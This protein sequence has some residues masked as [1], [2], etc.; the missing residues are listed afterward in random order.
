MRAPRRVMG[1]WDG[2]LHSCPASGKILP[3]AGGSWTFSRCFKSKQPRGLGI[4]VL[5]TV[6]WNLLAPCRRNR[7]EGAPGEERRR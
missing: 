1:R 7:R 6:A 3:V 4:A 2:A 5:G